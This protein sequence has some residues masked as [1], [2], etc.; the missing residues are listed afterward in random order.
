[1]SRIGYITTLIYLPF[2]VV[3]S[4]MQDVTLTDFQQ[5]LFNKAYFL[6]QSLVVFSLSAQIF[7]YEFSKHKRLLMCSMCVIQSVFIIY[8][9]IDWSEALVYNRYVC[10]AFAL[11]AIASFAITIIR[12]KINDRKSKR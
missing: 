6:M 5:L 9:F 12:T 3:Y 11:I 1:M 2:L 4:M 10:A 7:Y 8:L